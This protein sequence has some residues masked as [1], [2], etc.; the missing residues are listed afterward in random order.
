MQRIPVAQR[1]GLAEAARDHGYAYG[2]GAGVPYWDETAY[3]RFT[4]RQIEED[5]EGAAE[6]IDAMCHEL[7]G[8]ALA[9][10]AIFRRLRLPEPYWDYVA[11]S[12][13]RGEPDLYGRMDLCYDG[14]APAKLLEYNAD[15]PTTLYEAAVFQ[16]VWLEQ[17]RDLGL[18]PAASDQF[19]L[20]HEHLVAAFAA[21][22]VEDMLHLACLVDAEEDRET[23][24]YLEECA[25]EAGLATGLLAV[26]DIGVDAVGRFTD[27]DD[28]V[29]TTLFKLYPWEW[30]FSEPFARHLVAS[31]V[32]FIEPPWKA[33]LSTKGLL[34]LLWDRFE[35]HPNLLPAYFEDDPAAAA[36][37]D[38]HVRKPLYSRRG[39]NIEIVAG[40]VAAARKPGPYGE[41]GFVLQA[42][43]PLP[44]FAGRY[45]VV[46][47]WLVAGGASAL[48]I[49][50]GETL[51]TDSAANFVPHVILD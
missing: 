11:E 46:G 50:E 34:A 27:L 15:T 17:A 26:G 32:R 45:P 13:R 38:D 41:E 9:D 16:W 21:M 44:Q 7:L 37:A 14:A 24:L 12:W 4:L 22:T 39:A 36:L 28:R 51:I 47:C 35:G 30:I 42:C 5:L 23:V 31:G 29:I 6:E 18:I 43:R 20:L 33:L 2:P 49:R 10:D 1:P 8:A 48:S 25:A 19:A 3:Y 40:G